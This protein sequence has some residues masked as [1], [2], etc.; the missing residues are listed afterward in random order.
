[1]WAY[2]GIRYRYVTMQHCIYRVASTCVASLESEVR[3][4]AD[5]KSSAA[6]LSM[7]P[8]GSKSALAATTE[9]TPLCR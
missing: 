2:V 8:N 4:S 6:F 9:P 7:E 1:M 5:L 3:G